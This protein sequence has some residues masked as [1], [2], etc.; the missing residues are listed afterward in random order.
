MIALQIERSCRLGNNILQ[1]AQA[2]LFARQIG[3][4]IISVGKLGVF[5]FNP[6]FKQ[7]ICP[8]GT[9]ITRSEVFPPKTAVIKDTFFG[10]TKFGG[11]KFSPDYNLI[12]QTFSDIRSVMGINPKNCGTSNDIYCHVRAGDIFLRPKPKFNYVQPPLAFYLKSIVDFLE[13]E[14]C[15]KIKVVYET[16]DN[17]VVD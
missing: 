7:H 15:E 2:L 1:F 3:A 16:K 6:K 11:Q 13:T 4:K 14:E 5:L 8:D 10:A 12:K 17:P 9:I